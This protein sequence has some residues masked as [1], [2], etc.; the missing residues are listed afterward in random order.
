MRVNNILCLFHVIFLSSPQKVIIYVDKIVPHLKRH[1]KC[2][3]HVSHLLLSNRK[4]RPRHSNTR[5]FQVERA[6]TLPHLRIHHPDLLHLR[7]DWP[8]SFPR[9][10]ISGFAQTSIRRHRFQYCGYSFLR[11]SAIKAYWM[12]GVL[13]FSFFFYMGKLNVW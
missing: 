4:S 8:E 9:R 13:L 1:F 3:I 11:G 5:S 6:K 2:I 7:S 10:T 12:V